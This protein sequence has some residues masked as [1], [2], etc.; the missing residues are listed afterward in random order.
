MTDASLRLRGLVRAISR[1]SFEPFQ[2]E[3][4]PSSPIRPQRSVSA[5]APLPRRAPL[6]ALQTSLNRDRYF[7]MNRSLTTADDAIVSV[8]VSGL[9]AAAHVMLEVI[10]GSAMLAIAPMDG[11]VRTNSGI[12]F[13]LGELSASE[14]RTLRVRI[15]P[16][17]ASRP[18]RRR[19]AVVR[20]VL[21][22]R[23]TDS[24][25]VWARVERQSSD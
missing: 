20:V 10:M 17:P 16:K 5:V 19:V 13:D 4:I 12:S 22:G 24:T 3:G 2:P 15:H 23:V 11:A 7:W 9:S 14:R 6:M 21:D 25:T 8:T 18:G 1:A